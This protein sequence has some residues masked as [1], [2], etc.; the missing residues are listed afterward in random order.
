MIQNKLGQHFL[1]NN[2]IC[3][4]ISKTLSFKNY[5]IVIEIGPG[6]GA[7]TFFLLK[8]CKNL[9][10]IE[11]DYKLIFFLRKKFPLL[12]N[13][14]IYKNFLKWNPKKINKL[15]S[16][17]LVGNFP[18]NISSQILFYI[19]KYRKYIPECIGMF[20]KEVAKRII[21]KKGNKSYGILSIFI[22]AYYKVEY[23]FSVK[24]KFFSPI[25]KV[26]GAVLRL[27]RKKKKINCNEKLFFN[28]VKTAFKQRR[29]IIKNSLKYFNISFLKKSILKKRS[30]QLSIKDF[31]FIVNNIS[32]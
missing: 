20:Q 30:E 9:F 3:K 31:I 13:R 14:I 2:N 18:Y 10:L 28:I 1:K 11:I 23:L 15:S 5:D 8:K 21:S 25:P 29:K 12:R 32:L 26:K 7:L 17:A 19:L 22:Q 4:K 16:F 24:K 27:T 6:K